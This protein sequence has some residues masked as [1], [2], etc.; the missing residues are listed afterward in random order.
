MKSSEA[1]ERALYSDQEAATRLGIS[2]A[3]VWR[4]ARAKRLETV[5]ILGSTRFTAQSVDRIAAEG[6]P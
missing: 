4:L 5:K 2:R 1:I 3:S 6:A